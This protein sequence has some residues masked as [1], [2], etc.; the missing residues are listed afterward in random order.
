MGFPLFVYGSA[1]A[2]EARPRPLRFI[3]ALSDAPQSH[4]G[5]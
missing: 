1:A 4:S 2:A 5:A 3:A